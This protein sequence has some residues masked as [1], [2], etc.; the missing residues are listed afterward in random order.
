[1]AGFEVITEENR[2][3]Y[4]LGYVCKAKPRYETMFGARSVKTAS[5]LCMEGNAYLAAKDFAAA[6]PR[7][8]LGEKIRERT[9]GL[10]SPV[11]AK[12]LEEH[13]GC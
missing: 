9:L 6:D 3:Q 1:M 10:T 7:F 13:A 4:A 2:C 12:T 11:L 8:R 5:V